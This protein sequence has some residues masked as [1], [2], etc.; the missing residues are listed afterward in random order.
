[1][2]VDRETSRDALTAL[3]STGVTSAQ[4][5]YGYQKGDLGSE[6]PVVVVYS[7]GANHNPLT[8]QG[9]ETRFF[10]NVDAYILYNDPDNASYNED[11]AEDILDA[12]ENEIAQ[13]IEDNRSNGV[14]WGWMGYAG[15]SVV[16][17]IVL[18]G[19]TYLWESAP[20]LVR[21]YA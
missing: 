18:G 10:F 9:N 5:V 17:K 20:I 15:E 4:S 12:V 6:S 1:M 11:N 8:Q 21:V 2:A 13:V 19:T 3:L 7:S 16:L 14:I